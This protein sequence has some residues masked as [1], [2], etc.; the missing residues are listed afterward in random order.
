MVSCHPSVEVTCVF[1]KELHWAPWRSIFFIKIWRKYEI[2]LLSIVEGVNCCSMPNP[3]PDS[4][5]ASSVGALWYLQW[6]VL[7]TVW[8]PHY[9]CIFSLSISL[10]SNG[11]TLHLQFNRFPLPYSRCLLFIYCLL[12][13]PF[14]S[15]YLFLCDGSHWF[16]PRENWQIMRYSLPHF[17]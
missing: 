11:T 12:L 14:F 4:S 1:I 6:K 3:W 15:F 13:K 10:S 17:G 16:H 2:F 8:L 7:W 5:P 9:K